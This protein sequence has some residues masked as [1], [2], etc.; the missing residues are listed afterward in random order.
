M[1]KVV[2]YKKV[3]KINCKIDG[4]SFDKPKG[5]EE[6]LTVG[7]TGI[8]LIISFPIW[9]IPYLFGKF[10]VFIAK[11]KVVPDKVY[12]CPQCSSQINQIGYL[13]KIK[14]NEC[15]WYGYLDNMKTKEQT[16]NEN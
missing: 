4:F 7:L 10:I 2:E 8:L 14:C 9:I 5:L 1:T 11:K 15:G 13:L 6:Y 12:L 16:Q 3:K